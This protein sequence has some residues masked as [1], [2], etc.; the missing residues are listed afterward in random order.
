MSTKTSNGREATADRTLK[1]GDRNES[2]R[3]NILIE[4]RMQ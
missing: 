1:S 3:K 2:G 4:E